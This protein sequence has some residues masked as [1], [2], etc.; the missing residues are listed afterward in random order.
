MDKI[1]I[2][3]WIEAAIDGDKNALERL[4]LSVQNLI[5]NL[6]LRM[7]G[8][9]HD[10][11]DAT[12]DILIRIMTNLLSFR[13]ESS[14]QT[15]V[16][17]LSV[18]YLINYK[19]SIFSK[20]PLDFEFYGNDIRFGKTDEV[21]DFINETDRAR[22]AEE[23]KLSCTNVM[24]QCLDA[25]NRCIFILG[26]MFRIDSK[27]AGEA[28]EI[29]PA[30]YR[31]RLSRARKK[32]AAFLTEYCGLTGTGTC[33]CSK[34]VTYAISKGRLNPNGLEYTKLPILE[35]P[36]LMEYKEEMEKLDALACTFEESPH[37][38]STILAGEL[39]AKL[40]SSTSLKKIQKY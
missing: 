35:Q 32:M 40:L 37:Y 34:R 9:V 31:K 28:L 21:E 39:M 13:R 22:F 11:E 18:N 6:S 19:K 1:E 5:F 17:R 23:L 24:L 4:L 7:L 30:A 15:W 33:S 16:Y 38:V 14:F 12:Q 25:E 26:T 8:S 3:Q 10:A 20:R 2:N 27:T 36:I 29:T